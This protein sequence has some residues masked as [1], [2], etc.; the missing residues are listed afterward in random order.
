MSFLTTS[1]KLSTL[2][3]TVLKG[4]EQVGS[5][6]S[7][8]SAQWIPT[9]HHI[10]LLDLIFLMILSHC[11]LLKDPSDTL[12]LHFSHKMQERRRRECSSW[13]VWN[14]YVSGN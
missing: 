13:L 4:K 8:G 3:P 14:M 5:L 11:W 10:S 12:Q 9:S 7:E 2:S 6:S 1:G